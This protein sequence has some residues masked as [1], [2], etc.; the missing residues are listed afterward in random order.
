MF[1]EMNNDCVQLPAGAKLYES[2]ISNTMILYLPKDL[3]SKQIIAI[4]HVL[5]R[6]DKEKKTVVLLNVPYCK[7]IGRAHV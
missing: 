2:S 6:K 1:N 4:C 3:P 5:N 7:E